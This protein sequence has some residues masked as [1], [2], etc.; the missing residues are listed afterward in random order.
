MG[1]SKSMKGIMN[2]IQPLG[3]GYI[4]AFLE[5]NGYDVTI[6]ECQCLGV[7]Y[8]AIVDKLRKSQPDIVGMSV[9]QQLDLRDPIESEDDVH[10]QWRGRS[11]NASNRRSHSRLQ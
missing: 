5:R 7:N 1:K 6:E 3:L 11:R 8:Q 4:A 9:I 2:V 10:N